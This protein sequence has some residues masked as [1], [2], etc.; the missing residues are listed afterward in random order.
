MDRQAYFAEGYITG[1]PTRSGITSRSWM[2]FFL[3]RSPIVTTTVILSG[4][5]Q[6]FRGNYFFDYCTLR[7]VLY[8]RD[9]HPVFMKIN[10]IDEYKLFT[11]AGSG[12]E[13]KY[14]M[15]YHES[16]AHIC[17]PWGF[18]C[19]FPST[20]LWP[21]YKA[22][23]IEFIDSTSCNLLSLWQ[24]ICSNALASCK[25]V[26]PKPIF[27]A[28]IRSKVSWIFSHSVCLVL[29]I[30]RADK[31]DRMGMSGEWAG[32]NISFRVLKVEV[33]GINKIAYIYSRNRTPFSLPLIRRVNLLF[34]WTILN[35]RWGRRVHT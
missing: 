2:G 14:F 4:S 13:Y 23:C 16:C 9:R 31:L 15:I 28:R 33:N 18:H 7:A 10:T 3:S 21:T 6:V 24:A 27:R 5:I 35:L 11:Q 22:E 25:R 29:C 17:Y 1:T 12:I 32:E 8:V 26:S 19:L 20:L 34:P 30:L